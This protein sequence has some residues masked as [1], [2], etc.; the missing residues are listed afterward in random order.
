MSDNKIIIIIIIN[1]KDNADIYPLEKQQNT[2]VK[3]ERKP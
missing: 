3:F 1:V 2:R